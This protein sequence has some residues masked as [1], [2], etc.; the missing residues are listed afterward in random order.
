MQL[1][2]SLRSG[3]KPFWRLPTVSRPLEVSI[4]SSVSVETARETW[5][6]VTMTPP[7]SLPGRNA[8]RISCASAKAHS[9]FAPPLWVAPV[10]SEH[11]VRLPAQSDMILNGDL[12][13]QLSGAGDKKVA[14][15]K[16]WTDADGRPRMKVLFA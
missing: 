8:W 15:L 5:Q 4:V 13:L 6:R 1:L 10:A 9:V 7:G 16:P 2:K 14:R 12:F 3:T 11:L